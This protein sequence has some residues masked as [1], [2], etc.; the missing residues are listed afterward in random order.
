[1]YHLYDTNCMLQDV[2]IDTSDVVQQY[3]SINM[4]HLYGTNYWINKYITKSVVSR[5]M[6]QE[7]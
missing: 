6:L 1:M 4:Y 5:D 2:V 7:V 3:V